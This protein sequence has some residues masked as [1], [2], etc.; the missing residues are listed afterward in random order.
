MG[1]HLSAQADP[2]SPG[3][4]V[5]DDLFEEAQESG[6]KGVTNSRHARA[7]PVGSRKTLEEIVC[8]DAEKIGLMGQMIDEEGRG[9]CFD[10]HA[11]R[12]SAGN[13]VT[14]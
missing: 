2:F 4:R 8:S 13:A 12:Y 5:G 3:A 9:R 11:K 14:V 10:H 7:G 6:L 1:R